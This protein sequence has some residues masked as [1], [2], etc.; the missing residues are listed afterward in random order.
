MEKITFRVDELL[1]GAHDHELHRLPVTKTLHD[2]VKAAARADGVDI[3]VFQRRAL[4]NELR[5]SGK[6]VT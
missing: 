4:V 6:N 3:T 5:R 2:A 1:D